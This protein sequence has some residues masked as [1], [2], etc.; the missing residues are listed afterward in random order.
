M[1]HQRKQCTAGRLGLW[2]TAGSRGA[3][4]LPLNAFADIQ[5]FWKK[6]YI[7][8][9]K[10]CMCN[11]Q[12]W[13]K[14]LMDAAVTDVHDIYWII[15]AVLACA[16]GFQ[17]P[18]ELDANYLKKTSRAF[19]LV[20]RPNCSENAPK[21]EEEEE[22]YN[23]FVTIHFKCYPTAVIIHHYNYRYITSNGG[24][25]VLTRMLVGINQLLLSFNK[26][27]LDSRPPAAL[28]L[29]PRAPHE[30]RRVAVSMWRL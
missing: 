19:L 9:K 26:A 23:V 22:E 12:I 10:R 4:M 2:I 7:H 11:R 20:N 18:S 21:T 1:C 6:I 16:S 28:F 3:Q 13:W 25:T 24:E 14:T 27:P 15:R 8:V 5:Y 30:W 29:S 17:L